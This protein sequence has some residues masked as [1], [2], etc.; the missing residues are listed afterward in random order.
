M[1]YNSTQTKY[2]EKQNQRDRILMRSE[3][4]LEKGE[5]GEL[6]LHGYR[7]SVWGNEKI[8]ETKL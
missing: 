4:G 2:P 1:L 7:V 8:L 6:L 5:N 3:Q